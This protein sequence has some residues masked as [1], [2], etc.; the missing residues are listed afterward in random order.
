MKSNLKKASLLFTGILMGGTLFA[1]STDTLHVS[2]DYVK[3]FSGDNAFRTWSI[4][5]SGGVLTPF[6]IFGSNG[7]QDFTSP[8]AELGYGAYIKKQILP[9][10]G[11]QADF[12][13]GKL[14][15]DHSSPN[16]AGLI[17]KSYATKIQYAASLSANYT[18]AN[19]NWHYKKTAI[20]PYFTMG[21]GTMAYKPVLT[22]TDGSVS[23]FKTDNNGSISELYIPVGAGLK[24]NVSP[25]VNVDLGY[26][27]NFV[28]SDNVDGDIY[29]STNDKFSYAH[30]GLEFALGSRSKPQLA[31]H[32]PVSSMR[33]EYMWENEQTKN[34]LQGQIDAE[35]AKN[36]QLRND[37][38][39]TNAN[40]A[41]LTQDSDGD[42]V[43][44]AFDKCLN[45]PAGTKVDG[46][47]CPLPVVK[48]VTKVYVTEEDNRVVNEA[49]RNLEFDFNKATI[50]EHSFVSLN[51]LAQLLKDKGFNLKLAGY[52]DNVGSVAYNL[53]LSQ[54]RAEA[55]KT[56][57]VSKGADAGK[58]QAEGHGKANPIATNKTA[59]GRQQN[60]RVEFSLY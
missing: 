9:S 28:Y 57:L 39:V 3:P 44:D 6:T 58:I 34:Q 10:F 21:V 35:K 51:Q 25:G 27:V 56:Y 19:I 46:T 60:R 43:P 8:N 14:S 54:D 41:K 12:F 1:Q 4:G 22:Y 50:R 13:A 47:G 16:S 23:N 17:F 2:T 5:V 49:V 53:R 33:H 38:N 40:L 45:T 59:A 32:N 11:I 20:Q 48:S 52:T 18:L 31:T 36:V 15:A 26:Q 42:G 24:F 55:I 37:L 29:G 30:I 7:K